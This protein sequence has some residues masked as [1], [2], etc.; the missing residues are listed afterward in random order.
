M[1]LHLG[2][3]LPTRAPELT[4]HDRLIFLFVQYNKTNST[5]SKTKDI[6][7]FLDMEALYLLM[8][9]LIFVLPFV[10]YVASVIRRD[11]DGMYG[12]SLIIRNGV[13]MSYSLISA[14]TDFY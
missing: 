2:S 7:R 13:P 1:I 4:L 11:K 10:K 9:D 3:G 6:V 14:I 8:Q 5:T 12:K